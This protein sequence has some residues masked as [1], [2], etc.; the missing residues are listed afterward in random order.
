M[1]GGVGNLGSTQN[2]QSNTRKKEVDK[3]KN[4]ELYWCKGY[5]NR[6]CDLQSP[7]M[8]QICPEEPVVPVVHICVSC[9][10]VHKKRRE[11]PENDSTFPAKK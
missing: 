11:H 8:E 7:H 1:M 3:H 9:W 4:V 6:M 10:N 2:T 5:Q